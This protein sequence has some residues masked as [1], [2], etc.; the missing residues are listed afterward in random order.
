MKLLT[1]NL[2]HR[3]RRIPIPDLVPEAIKALGPDIRFN[4]VCTGSITRFLSCS[5][6]RFGAVSCAYFTR[7]AG[8]KLATD[9]LLGDPCAWG[10]YCP[11]NCAFRSIQF[12]ARRSP[13]DDLRVIGIRVPDYSR[14]PR[15][16]H[17]G[18]G[19]ALLRSR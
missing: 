10:N 5:S 11:A 12:P 14:K 18:I 8:R 1:W 13:Y 7:G 9:C 2:N 6:F 16:G 15:I 17:A 3:T 19:L 4:G